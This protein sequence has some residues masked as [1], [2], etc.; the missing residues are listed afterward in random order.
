MFHHDMFTNSCTVYVYVYIY[1]PFLKVLCNI[2]SISIYVVCYIFLFSC[3]TFSL[4]YFI[5]TFKYLN[6]LKITTLT[7][8][9]LSF[10]KIKFSISKLNWTPF[11]M[12]FHNGLNYWLDR[13]CQGWRLLRSRN[14]R[15]TRGGNYC[16]E[17][18]FLNYLL[19]TFF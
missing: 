14:L 15:F 18:W 2:I 13:K 12:V 3:L 1:V 4:C 10:E 6:G 11:T 19:F 16:L 5:S 9:F 17:D 7:D 8:L